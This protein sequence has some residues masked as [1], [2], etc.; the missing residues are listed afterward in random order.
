MWR[1]NLGIDVDQRFKLMVRTVF[2]KSTGRFGAKR[3]KNDKWI[4]PQVFCENQIQKVLDLRVNT[5]RSVS[6]REV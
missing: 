5:G 4:G 6:L 1:A 2:N 3:R